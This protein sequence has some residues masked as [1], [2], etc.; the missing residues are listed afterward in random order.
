MMLFFIQV[1]PVALLLVVSKYRVRKIL[2]GI[3]S[4]HCKIHLKIL[5]VQVN[6]VG[7][8]EYLSGKE[9]FFFISNHLTFLDIFVYSSIN[10]TCYV[11]SLDMKKTPVLGQTIQMAGC[12]YVDRHNSK[13]SEGEVAELVDGLQNGLSIMV[14]PEAKSTN[15][16]E[17][18]RF[19]K[20]LFNAPLKAKHRVLPFTLNYKTIDDKPIT[21]ENRDKI[22]WYGDMAFPPTFFHLLNHDKVE[23][24]VRI[25]EPI[26]PTAEQT[27][28]DLANFCHSVV[29]NEYKQINA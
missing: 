6:V 26:M 9:N 10:P 4:R 3:V 17:V 22:F 15:G 18:Q 12:L 27:D 13:N 21:L 2:N 25:H 23:V 8:K 28:I 20:T 11:T 1:G 24:E 7:N 19:R 16:E 14:F 5:N 29:S